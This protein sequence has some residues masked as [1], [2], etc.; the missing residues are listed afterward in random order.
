[1]VN[2]GK[3]PVTYQLIQFGEPGQLTSAQAEAIVRKMRLQQQAMHQSMQ[4]MMHEMNHFFDD[5]WSMMDK[6][7]FPVIMPVMVYPDHKPMK[8]SQTNP[9][10]PQQKVTSTVPANQAK[11]AANPTENIKK[12]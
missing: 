8:S 2:E 11:P 3:Q 9:G 4:R 1:T 7:I 5:Q 10:K 6:E 12:Q